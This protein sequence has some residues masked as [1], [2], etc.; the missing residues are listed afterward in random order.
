MQKNTNNPQKGWRMSATLAAALILSCTT[1]IGPAASAVASTQVAKTAAVPNAQLVPV[2]FLPVVMSSYPLQTIFGAEMSNIAPAGGLAQVTDARMNWVRKNGL[3]WSNVE[4]TEGDRNW[5]A[6]ANLEQEMKNASA[7][8]LKMILIVRSAPTWAQLINGV[9]CGPVRADKTAAFGNFMFDVVKRYSVAP[10]N[11][12]HWEIWNE[13]D[14]AY[15]IRVSDTEEFGCFGDLTAPNYGG[16]R[17]A[18][19][20][21]G[22]Y[23]RIKQADPD[24]QVLVGGLLMDC[25]PISAGKG[26]SARTPPSD[27]TASLF[28]EGILSG[29]GG[30]FFD[31][32]AF[33]GY[34]TYRGGLGK[35]GQ[36][37]FNSSWDTTGPSVHAKAQFLKQVLAKYGFASKALYNTETGVGCAAGCGPDSINTMAYYMMESFAGALAEGL[38]AQI[39]YSTLNPSSWLDTNLLNN[40]LTPRPHMI[41]LKTAATKFQDASFVKYVTTYPGVKIYELTRRGKRFWVAKSLDGTQRTISLPSTPTG[42]FDPFGNAVP[43]PINALLS[44]GIQPLYIDWN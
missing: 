36:G 31:G 10:Y 38:T 28:L 12:K 5:T 13:P 7:N 26:C 34:D 44:I 9:F 17:F 41:A 2:V 11:V 20:L 37:G 29:G 8:G 33:H 27:P 39:A 40:D 25:I 23:P 22:A 43:V 1:A 3:V 21:Q 18:Q 14:V 24:A 16:G 30:S 19:L 42:I 15:Q 32:V 4:P 35:Y 6:L